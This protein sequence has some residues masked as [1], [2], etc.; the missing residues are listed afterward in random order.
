MKT[1]FHNQYSGSHFEDFSQYHGQVLT[2]LSFR[3]ECR[4]YE[5]RAASL[6]GVVGFGYFMP[7]MH[8]M[9]QP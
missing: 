9:L 3:D 6:F 5:K 2:P 8:L 4:R 7:F 1:N